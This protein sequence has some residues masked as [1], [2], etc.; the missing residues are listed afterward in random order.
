RQREALEAK[1]SPAARDAH[2]EWLWQRLRGH[3]PDQFESL[4]AAN[5]GHPPMCLRVNEARVSRNAYKGELMAAGIAAEPCAL[6]GGGLRLGQPVEVTALPG[7][8]AGRVSVQD[9]AAQ[10]AAPLLDPQP[11]DRVLDAC[12]APGGKTGHLLERQP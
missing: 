12:C 4:I 2:P 10:L 6:A 11:G 9:E 5:N 1:L 8:L 3:W 7:F